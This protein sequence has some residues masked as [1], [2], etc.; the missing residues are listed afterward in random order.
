MMKNVNVSLI[1][2]PWIGKTSFICELL[3]EK[4]ALQLKNTI[5]ENKP[6]DLTNS[7][8]M[9]YT[10]VNPNLYNNIS[11]AYIEF[12]YS[13]LRD[14]LFNS[15]E[16]SHSNLKMFLSLFKFPDNPT[17]IYKENIDGMN[18]YKKIFENIS[19]QDF[20]K[21]YIYNPEI[22]GANLIH[23][24]RLEAPASKELWDLISTNRFD[25]ITFR[26][27]IWFDS[28]NHIIDSKNSSFTEYHNYLKF[29]S[30]HAYIFFDDDTKERPFEYKKLY[31]SLM[32][33]SIISRPTFICKRSNILTD[34]LFDKLTYINDIN[35]L[36]IAD[37]DDL[38]KAA[39]T[40]NHYTNFTDIEDKFK[41]STTEKDI[42]DSIKNYY[43]HSVLLPTVDFSN[44]TNNLKEY[45]KIYN[46]VIH[47]IFKELFNSLIEYYTIK[48]FFLKYK[49]EIKAII[50]D[51]YIKNFRNTLHISYEEYSVTFFLNYSASFSYL[52]N[53]ANQIKN[54][55]F[56][57][58]I[59]GIQG[60]FT[61]TKYT[62]GKS[63]L[64]LTHSLF[65]SFLNH[66]MVI[67]CKINE[68]DLQETVDIINLSI[69]YDVIEKMFLEKN[70]PLYIYIDK[71][72][73]NKVLVPFILYTIC[74]YLKINLEDLNYNNVQS[75]KYLLLYKLQ[76][77]FDATVKDLP[78][79]DLQK[80]NNQNFVDLQNMPN[81]SNFNIS[82]LEEEQ[83][84]EALT[85]V[86]NITTHLVDNFLYYM[87][88]FLP[89]FFALP[90]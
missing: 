5:I 67:F 68:K 35:N 1:G 80:V 49:E 88:Y 44:K 3:E 27:H 75:S 13:V 7:I 23:H 37:Y 19:F 51:T 54:N 87:I 24:I 65:R 14:F 61:T 48:T 45:R 46:Y 63:L 38:Q 4:A 16:N 57:G 56:W 77:A 17:L 55:N 82:L 26:E 6:N 52:I 10:L 53:L 18:D 33:E 78:S 79:I 31:H 29:D 72:I 85:L 9:Y 84:K 60:G 58:G 12:N 2:K 21:E 62:F 76:N 8:S 20:L 81:I 50:T 30:T 64:E 43:Y 22:N 39:M 34:K 36:T 42:E 40:K 25:S 28:I 70:N 66:K 15:K 83:L 47:C 41:L 73:N 59:V 89:E 32:S 11:I 86:E 69:A 90:E 71:H 74:E